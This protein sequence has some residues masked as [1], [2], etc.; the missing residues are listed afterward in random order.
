M[1]YS[2][3][4]YEY[5]ALEK[6]NDNQLLEFFLTRI[7]ETEE[8]WGLDD[9]V[10]WIIRDNDVSHASL[11]VWPYKNLANEAAIGHWQSLFAS[12]MS[13]EE[14]MRHTLDTM[15]EENILIEIIPRKGKHGCLIEAAK[16]LSI[17]EGMIDAGEYTLDG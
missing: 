2:P 10:E 5:S 11:P 8:V 4:G 12:D 1:R 16:L 13:L 17:L 15:K 9:T 3:Y 14:F 6:M 7:F